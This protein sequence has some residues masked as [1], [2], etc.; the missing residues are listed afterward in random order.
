[1]PATDRRRGGI[2]GKNSVVRGRLVLGVE[3]TEYRRRD[4]TTVALTE[5]NEPDLLEFSD[6]NAH[7]SPS[8]WQELRK[9]LDWKTLRTAL[10]I[11]AVVAFYG[12]MFAYGVMHPMSPTREGEDPGDMYWRR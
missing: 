6:R 7:L 8:F 2:A 10:L 12:W 11:A 3:G 5:M 9:W 1:M 4:G